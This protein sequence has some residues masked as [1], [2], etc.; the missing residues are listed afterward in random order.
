MAIDFDAYLTLEQKK[1]I[2]ESRL[3]QFAAE[4]YQAHLS[5]EIQILRGDDYAVSAYNESLDL[6]ESAISVHAD[7]LAKL[8]SETPAN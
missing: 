3:Q 4:A 6:I 5:K 1:L 8:D 2:V 7:E